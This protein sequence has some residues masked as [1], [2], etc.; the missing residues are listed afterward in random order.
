MN[1]YLNLVWSHL[2]AFV[3][4]EVAVSDVSKFE[5]LINSVCFLQNL[6]VFYYFF[7]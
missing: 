4:N 5:G 2:I 3:G 1:N 6:S 7:F